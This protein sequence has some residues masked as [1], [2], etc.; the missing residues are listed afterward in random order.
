MDLALITP[1]ILTWNEAPN[2]GRCL[3]PL[4]QFPRV[5]VVDSFSTDETADIARS[6]P[7][8]EFVERRFDSFAEQ[9]N[10]GLGLIHT[11]WVLSF[12]SDYIA[13]IDFIAE[14]KAL[15]AS[16]CVAG[17]KAHFRYCIEGHPLRGTLYPPRTCLYRR[18][19]AG[20]VNDGH[21]HRVTVNGPV[22]NLKTS[23]HHDDRKSLDHWL[24]SQRKYA[25]QESEKLGDSTW[26]SLGWA[27]R[28]R[29]SMILAPFVT[30]IY[31]LFAKGLLFDGWRGWFYTL[32]RVLAEVMLAL[33][34]LDHR[35]QKKLPRT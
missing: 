32:Q 11:E 16:P 26:Q 14:L 25:S 21:G 13:D 34:L 35:L 19:L 3:D 12:D 27:D 4:R 23:L 24:H 20:Y 31:C 8:V 7:N 29:K 10:F 1:M 5:L 28:L 22:G 30:L 33:H 15:P 18:E 9:C 6:H 2:L 17:Y